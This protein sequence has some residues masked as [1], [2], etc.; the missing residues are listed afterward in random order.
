[1]TEEAVDLLSKLSKLPCRP[2]VQH[3]ARTSQHQDDFERRK[4]LTEEVIARLGVLETKISQALSL[5]S[6]FLR[7]ETSQTV[8]DQASPQ[9]KDSVSNF[10]EAFVRE[11]YGGPEVAVVGGPRGPAGQLIRRMFLEAKRAAREAREGPRLEGGIAEEDPLHEDSQ[12]IFPR[13]CSAEYVL[14]TMVR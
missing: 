9:D 3:Y 4:L 13:P 2:E 12:E 7:E 1:M 6:K 11:L 14:R 5:R 10:M 8:R